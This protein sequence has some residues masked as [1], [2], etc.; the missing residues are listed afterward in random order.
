MMTC[1][2][3]FTHK[4]FTSIKFKLQ[5]ALRLMEYKEKF[6]LMPIVSAQM[7]IYKHSQTNYLTLSRSMLDY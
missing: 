4:T 5:F 3:I 2:D 6:S 7:I 1:M